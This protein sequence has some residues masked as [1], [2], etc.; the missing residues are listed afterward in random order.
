MRVPKKKRSAKTLRRATRKAEAQRE[1][2][3]LGP[4]LDER[5]MTSNFRTRQ[6]FGAASEVR[7]IEITPEMRAQYEKKP[8]MPTPRAFFNIITSGVI[9]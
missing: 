4:G 5:V 2:D 3:L 9:N 7:K 1:R 8:R 6:K